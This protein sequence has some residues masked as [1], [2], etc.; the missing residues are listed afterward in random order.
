MKEI[1]NK[2]TAAGIGK[3]LLNEPLANHTTWRIGGPADL[4]IIPKD[5][6]SLVY[7]VQLIHRH[8]IPWIVI[9]RGSNLLVRDGGIRGA[10]FKVA[11]G[12]SH[13]EFKGE[14][15]RV[16]AGYSMIRLTVEAGKHGLTGLEFAGGIPGSV[17]GAVYMNAG[18]H[19]SDLSRILKE[20]EVLFENGETRVLTNEE[21]KFRYRTSLL[22][23]R[24]GIV[25]E[26]VLQLRKG[27]RKAISAA[28][29]SY[30]NRRRL[31]QPLQLPCAGSVFRNPPGDHAGRLI[32]AAGLKGYTC[33]GAQISEIHANFI[34]NRGGALATD[35]L[36]LMEHVR[37]VVK[38]TFGVDLHPEVLVVGEG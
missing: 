17:G 4:F 1:A 27:D 24:K 2:L 6:A 14:E 26:A 30:K 35:V 10:V 16:G 11:E 13:C 3:V 18:A 21:L 12:L 20:A 5:K 25:L 19:G 38:E 22:Q 31:T 29:A 23:E 33:G 36:T 15:V 8:K 37:T 7:A 9:G 28:L 34:V 32:E